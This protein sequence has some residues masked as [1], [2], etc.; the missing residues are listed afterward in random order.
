MQPA[1]GTV[2]ITDSKRFKFFGLV[3]KA[4]ID[5]SL[6]KVNVKKCP[7]TLAALIDKFQ[8]REL[9]IMRDKEIMKPNEVAYFIEFCEKAFMNKH[10]KVTFIITQYK[11]LL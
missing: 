5:T 7:K 2:I 1:S 10:I 6:M 9:H 4:H 3:V 11:F 8:L